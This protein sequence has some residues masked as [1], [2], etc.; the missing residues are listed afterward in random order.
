MTPRCVMPPAYVGCACFRHGCQGLACPYMQLLVYL[1]AQSMGWDEEERHKNPNYV[2]FIEATHLCH[3]CQE[4][5]ELAAGF[6][7]VSVNED[8]VRDP[9]ALIEHTKHEWAQYIEGSVITSATTSVSA[10]R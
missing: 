1:A 4:M 7:A 2:A 8:L 6:T 5:I 9:E 3:N 10:L